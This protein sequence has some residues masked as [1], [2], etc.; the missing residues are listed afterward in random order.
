M[1]NFTLRILHGAGLLMLLEFGM[2]QLTSGQ[3]P[4]NPVTLR[5]DPTT[6]QGG[7][8]S[9]LID[10]VVFTPLETNPQ[11]SF[12]QIDQLEVTDKYFIILDQQTN[13]ILIFTRKGDF[14][15][16]IELKKAYHSGEYH[17][18][19]FNYNKFTHFIEIPF[20]RSFSFCYNTDGQFVKKMVVFDFEYGLI[21]GKNTLAYYSYHSDPRFK[22]STAYEL[23]VAKDSVPL[24]K[25]FPYNMKTATLK[26]KDMLYSNHINFYRLDDTAA[27]FL[28]PYDYTLYTLSPE[29]LYA[30]YQ[31]IFP[32]MNSLP[33]NFTTDSSLNY[34][35]LSFIEEN[36]DIIYGL[37][38][39]Y[40]VGDNLFFKLLD[41]NTP[42]ANSYLYNL[43]SNNLLCIDKISPDKKSYYLPITDAQ[44]GVNFKNHGFLTEDKGFLFTSYSSQTLFQQEEISLNKD[45][46]YPPTLFKYLNNKKNARSNPIIIQMRFKTDL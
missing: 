27:F 10:S 6:A 46:K 1:K 39:V 11:S 24:K 40:K 25:Y 13:S 14:H 19:A 3:N 2:I 31:F 17:I 41:R 30:S 38:N 9:Q 26:D 45:F 32:A 35:R 4:L 20:S 44:I 42:G 22:D 8:V 36:K 16:K 12:G 29:T 34:K 23:V 7:T 43:R 33:A 28:R 37:S 5:I 21:L 18:P 15:A